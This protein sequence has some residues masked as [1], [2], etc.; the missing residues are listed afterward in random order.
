MHVGG[1]RHIPIVDENDEPVKAIRL[2]A[3]DLIP[4]RLKNSARSLNRRENYGHDTFDCPEWRSDL[5]CKKTMVTK[6]AMW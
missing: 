3:F 2:P 5:V 1:Y 6:E 4:T